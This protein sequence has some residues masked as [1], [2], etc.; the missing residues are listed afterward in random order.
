SA[1]GDRVVQSRAERVRGM[2][3]NPPLIAAV[4]GLVAGQVGGAAV[5]PDAL[6]EAARI[7]VY[8]L[9]PCGFLLVGISLATE[10]EEGA[11]AFPPRFDAPVATALALRLIAAPA[12]VLAGSAIIVDMPDAY[13]LQ[14]AMPS[15]INSLVVA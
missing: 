15:G 2:L 5:A 9:L 4:A 11:L 6:V 14:A 8:G 12:V 7:V 1:F 3:V 13:L 10:A